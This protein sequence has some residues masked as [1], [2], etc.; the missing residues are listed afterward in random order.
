MPGYIA[1]N[2]ATEPDATMTKPGNAGDASA[3]GV[4]NPAAGTCRHP[5]CATTR[6]SA[7]GSAWKAAPDNA[8]IGADL[9]AASHI[10]IV[11]AAKSRLAATR[12]QLAAIMAQ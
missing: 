12:S 6:H 11:A 1:R 3:G 4:L 2:P 5:A 8:M 7:A 10:G 9:A